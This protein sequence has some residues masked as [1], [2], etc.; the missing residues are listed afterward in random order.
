MSRDRIK[1]GSVVFLL[2]LLLVLPASA[3]DMEDLQLFDNANLSTYG[4]GRGPQEG[5]FFTYD[6]LYWSIS[7]PR[8]EQIGDP[9]LTRNVYYD[10]TGTPKPADRLAVQTNTYST[11]PFRAQFTT[12]QRIQFGR[13][14]GHQGWM[15]GGYWL[16]EQKQVCNAQDVN[17]AF[18]D[19]AF[20]PAGESWLQ[21]YVWNDGA[22]SPVLS[23]RKNLPIT[24]DTMRI[25]NIVDN[26]SIECM[27]IYRLHPGRAGGVLE[28]FGGVRYLEF[29]EVF[30]VDATGGV[31]ADS[32]WYTAADNHLIG[33][34]IGA[35]WSNQR[36]RWSL[37]GEGRFFAAFNNQNIRQD[38]LIGSELDPSTTTQGAPLELG[39]T[40]F[41]YW[42]HQTEWAPSV[43]L[44]LE[45]KWQWTRLV[46]FKAGWT[47]IYMDGIARPSKMVRY[48][49]DASGAVMGITNDNNRRG[50]LINGLTLGVELNR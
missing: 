45:A 17:V 33:P 38:G 15:V 7:A 10:I 21:G 47:G 29:N 30:S 6:G 25:R 28:L 27:Y 34:Q 50:V 36:G 18:Q 1:S 41:S 14:E 24:F 19:D 4:G 37:V 16:N 3:Q 20:G 2:I 42:L 48:E 49:F 13:V 5:F 26:W 11:A 22:V 12:G 9:N 39:P 32:N 31:L 43:E 8:A 46:S 35:R 44:R 40:G 23:D